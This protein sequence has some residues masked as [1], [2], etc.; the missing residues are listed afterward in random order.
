VTGDRDGGGPEDPPADGVPPEHGSEE[1][2][3]ETLEGSFP[4][5]DPPPFWSGGPGPDAGPDD[6]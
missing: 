4:A 5:S 1:E 6:A 3:D 2:V